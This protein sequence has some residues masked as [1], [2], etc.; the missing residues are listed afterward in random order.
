MEKSRELESLMLILMLEVC[1]VGVGI[2][3]YILCV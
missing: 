3:C 1:C 2:F